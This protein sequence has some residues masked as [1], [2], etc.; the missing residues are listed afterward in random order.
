MLQ[1]ILMPAIMS[2]FWHKVDASPILAFPMRQKSSLRRPISLRF[3]ARWSQQKSNRTF[4]SR[5]NCFRASSDYQRYVAEPLGEKRVQANEQVL[6]VTT[7][8]TGA[9]RRVSYGKGW[10]Q[11]LL[12]S[13]RYLE[14]L[15]NDRGNLLILLLQ[16]P[17][18]ALMLVLMVRFEIGTGVF[19]AN[20][21]RPMPYEYSHERSPPRY[22]SQVRPS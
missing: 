1:T 15:K 12:L 9:S 20:K 11:F 16:A 7:G 14:L 19:D 3:I 13:M 21:L 17:V 5:Q 6:K 8:D 10:S 4:R 2:A 22:H 18:I